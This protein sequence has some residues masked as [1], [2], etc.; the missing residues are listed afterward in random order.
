[1]FIFLIKS[2]GKIKNLLNYFILQEVLGLF[3][4][5]LK[6]FVFQILIIF[7]K[8]GV[9]P[10]HFWIFSVVVGLRINL[11]FWF[12]TFQKLVYLSI[13]INWGLVFF[14]FFFFGIL[15]CFF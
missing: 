15:I 6:N 5:F 14:Y 1:V 4:V 12:L 8:V 9:R 7:I 11:I 2:E 10:L 3:F 13:L